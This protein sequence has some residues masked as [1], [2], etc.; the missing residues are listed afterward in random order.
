MKNYL[1]FK[2]D[3]SEARLL[4]LLKILVSDWSLISLILIGRNYRDLDLGLG[5]YPIKLNL[6]NPQ[7][8]VILIR[9]IPFSRASLIG[10]NSFH[11]PVISVLPF[12]SRIVLNIWNF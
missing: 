9:K 5:D 10:Q 3:Q 12:P 7:G 1:I 6:K 8:H 11:F 2:S 4:F